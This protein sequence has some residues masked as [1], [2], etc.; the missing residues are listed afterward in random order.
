[1]R[2]SINLILIFLTIFIVL[3]GTSC[4]AE[5]NKEEEN[6]MF[7]N[8]LINET[9][10]YLLQHAHNPVNWYAWGD[11]ALNKAVEENKLMIVSIGY[12]ACHW[13]HVMEK[14]SF[15][16]TIVAKAMN[17]HYI[18]VKVDREERPDVDQVYMDAAY[19][20]NRRG[21]W[22]L[23][24]ITMPDGRP[25]FAGTYFP[26]EDWLKI[27]E[28]FSDTF[29]KN[30]ELFEQE[31]AKITNLLRQ[32]RIPGYTDEEPIFKI[33]DLKTAFSYGVNEIDFDKG[34][35]IGAPKFPMPNI[36]EFFLSYYYHTKEA[37]ALEAVE[38]VLDNMGNG[39]IYDQ[40]GGGFARYSTDAI[41]K[42]PHFE[43]MLYDNGQLVS[44]YSNAYKIT[45]NENYKRIVYQT[46]EFVEREMMDKSGGFYS[47]YDADSEGEEGKYYVWKKKE[48]L[49]LLGDDGEIISDYYTVTENGNWEHDKNILFVTDDIDDLLKKNNIDEKTFNKKLERAN[50]TLF[51][52]R[53]KRVKPG[54]DDKILT[55]WNALMLRGYCDAFNAFGEKK[56]L[57]V[58]V[59]NAKF[60]SGTMMNEDGQL[61]RNFKNGTRTINAFLG[62]Y[63][64]TIEAFIALYESTFDEQWLYKARLLADYVIEHFKDEKSGLFYFTSDIDDSLIA[65][66]VELSDNVIPAS[67][68]AL[69]KGFFNLANYF[70][71]KDFKELSANMLSKMKANF[72]STP[73]Y[74]SNWG[75]LMIDM[76]YP[77]YEVAIVGS[78]FED[79]R[80]KL[81]SSF[82]PNI[83]LLGGKDEGTLELLSKKLVDGKTMIYVCE[84]KNCKLP[85]EKIT[86]AKE[87][88]N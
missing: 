43:K 46:L 13:C 5:E 9:S 35:T 21:G 63:A 85:V 84:N 45:G 25:V 15:E 1:M 8:N 55:S 36:Y 52:E 24:V 6:H 42:V 65:R 71:D 16:D 79:K 59:T 11:E 78:D 44:L 17:D 88:L 2:E 70:Y 82:Y 49:N 41:W 29:T 60:I 74:H 12:S 30:P 40:I 3:I 54:L 19:L 61:Y 75:N 22:P 31:A 53:E 4:K 47:A 81:G 20:I 51:N 38:A 58:A 56:F 66:K 86:A 68:S 23:N 80:A 72:T 67:N 69:A 87:Q 34:G 50:R 27:I 33:D 7:T 57:E 10:P 73:L 76:V 77:F 26:K 18:S 28:Y 39:G 64:F 14:E 48:I 32:Q 62:D 83:L 37:K